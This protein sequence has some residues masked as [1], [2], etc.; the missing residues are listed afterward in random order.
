MLPN[1]G[2]I[3]HVEVEARLLKLKEFAETTPLNRIEMGDSD[4]G[5][6]T[7]GVSYQHVKEAYPNA[8]ILKLGLVHPL[9]EKMIREFSGKVKRFMIV[10]EMYAIF[11]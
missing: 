2:K 11:E 9:P 7:S 10:E 5:I 3:K 1:Y 8:S 6:L 4:M